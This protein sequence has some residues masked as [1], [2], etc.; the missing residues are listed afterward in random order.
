MMLTVLATLDRDSDL[1]F[2]VP[3]ILLIHYLY[4]LGQ[5]VIRPFMKCNKVSM[6]NYVHF[7]TNHINHIRVDSCTAGAGGPISDY[8]S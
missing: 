3:K 8:C 2:S 1:L 7:L 5:I 4:K 6:L